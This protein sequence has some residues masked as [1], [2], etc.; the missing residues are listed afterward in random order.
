[1]R[2]ADI[3]QLFSCRGDARPQAQKP[4]EALTPAFRS[5]VL[6][7]CSDVFGPVGALNDLWAQSH[8]KLTYLHGSPVLNARESGRPDVVEDLLGFLGVCTDEHFLD[9][10]EIVFRIEA[11][12]NVV[13]RDGLV[14]DFNQFLRVDDLPYSLT[15]FVWTTTKIQQ[16]GREYDGMTLTSI[17]QVI[18]RDSD[19]MHT[20]VVEPALQLLRESR[21]AGANAELLAAMADYRHGKY[22][23]CLTKTG[24][25]F[26]SVLKVICDSRGWTYSPTDTAAP[27]I[28]KVVK[29]GG[30]EGFFEQ[31]LVLIA[32]IRNRLSTAHGG[33]AAPRAVSAAKAEYAINAAAAAMLFL[34]RETE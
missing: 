12:N 16:H 21:F 15:G 28:S 34:V 13:D 23:D 10:L 3:F 33:G 25:A 14:A 19:Q 17:P 2:I 7:R 18:R 27:L 11:F 20:T 26:E 6:M 32:T 5:R 22:G 30:L 29:Q 4:P 31:P 9:F 1:M 8:T 24:S